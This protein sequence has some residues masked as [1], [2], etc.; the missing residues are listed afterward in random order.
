MFGWEEAELELRATAGRGVAISRNE[1]RKSLPFRAA[2]RK[3]S[4]EVEAGEGR[5]QWQL[6][7]Q[8]LY[9]QHSAL[10]TFLRPVPGG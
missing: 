2:A 6:L 1:M 9:K 4:G 10:V 3:S 7:R 8:Q 5:V